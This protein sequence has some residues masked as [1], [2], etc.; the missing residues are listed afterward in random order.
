[1]GRSLLFG[2]VMCAILLVAATTRSDVVTDSWATNTVAAPEPITGAPAQ[3]APG[4]ETDQHDPFRLYGTGPSLKYTSPKPLWQYSD[5]TAA[6]QAVVDRNR[7]TTAWVPV[8][9]AF[10]HATAERAHQAAASAAAA[11][12]GMENLSI[13]VVP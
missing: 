2:A 5:L 4:S 3:S 9:D 10:A 12:L 7:D 8:H 1:M 11:Q 13:G 6:E